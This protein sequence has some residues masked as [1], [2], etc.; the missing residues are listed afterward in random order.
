MT[1]QIFP[2]TAVTETLSDNTMRVCGAAV[3]S[4]P[5]LLV[6]VPNTLQFLCDVHAAVSEADSIYWK[7]CVEKSR[8]ESRK[9]TDTSNRF[10][11]AAAAGMP[12]GFLF[13]VLYTTPFNQLVTTGVGLAIMPL[14]GLA[15]LA[16]VRARALLRSKW[17]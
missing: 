2:C 5:R 12:L 16:V 9:L 3:D 10:Y 13:I 17:R 15:T 1:G 6:G 4:Q 7:N 11:I 14:P 8:K